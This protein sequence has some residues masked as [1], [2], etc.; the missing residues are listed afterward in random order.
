MRPCRLFFVVI[1]VVFGLDIVS[2]T[3]SKV[4]NLYVINISSMKEEMA[5]R[6]YHEF[7]LAWWKKTYYVVNHK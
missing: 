7:W 6:R 4:Q 3:N 1:L 5:S 2:L